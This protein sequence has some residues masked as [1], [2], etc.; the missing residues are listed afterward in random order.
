MDSA[1]SKTG[2]TWRSPL[3]LSGFCLQTLE[4]L[5]LGGASLLAMAFCFCLGNVA[6]LLRDDVRLLL[7]QLAAGALVFT[8]LLSY[9]HTM[10]S[11]RFAYQQGGGFIAKH[12]W[13]LIGY[14]LIIISLLAI[15]AITWHQPLQFLGSVTIVENFF[16]SLGIA[17]NWSKYDSIGELLLVCLLVLQIIMAGYHYGMQA[18]GVAIACGEKHGYR[19]QAE[20]KKY[21]RFNLYALWF[22]NL[23]SGYTFLSLFDSRGFNYRPVLFPSQ[24]QAAGAL[25]FVISTVLLFVKVIRPIFNQSRKLPPLSASVSI[26]S[27]WLWLQPFCQPYGFQAGVVPLAHGLQYMY[28]AGRAEVGG[29]DSKMTKLPR[30]KWLCLVVLFGLLVLFGCLTYTNLPV[31]LDG[32]GLVKHM[33]PNFFILAA[34]IFLNTHHYM[35][36]SV[37]WRGDSRL[38]CLMSTVPAA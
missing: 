36:D 33:V 3:A 1:R 26:L 9:P 20:Q 38:R 28:F 31:L 29:F 5:C 12:S 21:L 24:W 4:V 18:M 32:T 13:E 25:I 15:S 35:I 23:L 34:Y 14:P 30:A 19:L 17:L 22:V 10:W 37:V 7:A 6:F 16:A 2:L 8:A 27:V 11:Y